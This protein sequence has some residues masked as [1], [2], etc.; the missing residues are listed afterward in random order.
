[1]APMNDETQILAD[2]ESGKRQS[3]DELLPIVYKELALC[4]DPS[5]TSGVDGVNGP[6]LRY[7]S[8][9]ASRLE[10]ASQTGCLTAFDSGGRNI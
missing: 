5:I 7:R 10:M 2:L 4:D 9:P 1:M 6:I 8:K 3:S